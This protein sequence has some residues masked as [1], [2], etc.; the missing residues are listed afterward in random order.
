MI[1]SDDT[2][3]HGRRDKIRAMKN[4]WLMR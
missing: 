4:Q 3:V 2:P 1:V